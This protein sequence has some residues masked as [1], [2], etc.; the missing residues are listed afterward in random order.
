MYPQFGH[1]A[2]HGRHSI[3]F[4]AT[5]YVGENQVVFAVMTKFQAKYKIR[6]DRDLTFERARTQ[7]LSPREGGGRPMKGGQLSRGQLIL[8]LE[9]GANAV[10]G[11]KKAQVY[12]SGDH[13]DVR[14]IEDFL[15]RLVVFEV[16]ETKR[17]DSSTREDVPTDRMYKKQIAEFASSKAEL[18]ILLRHQEWKLEVMDMLQMSVYISK[19]KVSNY[20]T[21]NR[22]YYLERAQIV[23]EKLIAL[24]E[25][26]VEKGWVCDYQIRPEIARLGKIVDSRGRL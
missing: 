16:G 19:G 5:V 9:N 20:L 25:E 10:F 3:Y 18:E 23:R 26:G 2:S 22:R 4:P 11:S 14:E 7:N 13:E 6:V 21:V 1:V 24:L 12:W 17:F 15:N 8:T